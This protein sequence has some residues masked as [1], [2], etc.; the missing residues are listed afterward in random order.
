MKTAWV[1][2]SGGLLG[3]ALLRALA[4]SGADIFHPDRPIT[5]SATE[6]LDESI[7]MAVRRFGQRVAPANGWEIY[8]AAGVG[9]MGSD[10]GQ[11]QI[12]TRTLRILLQELARNDSLLAA[13]GAIAFAGS[14]GALYAG[15][16]DAVVSESSTLAP[17]TPYAFAK[18][19][20]EALLHEFC[21]AQPGH[22]LLIARISTLFGPQRAGRPG[23]GLFAHLAR[24]VFSHEPVKIFV[25]LDTMRDYVY[26][27]DAATAIVDILG[28]LSSR[29][30]VRM[31]IVA[32]ERVTTIADILALFGRVGRRQPRVVT[33]ATAL[34]SKY[35]S[36]LLFKSAVLPQVAQCYTTPLH[37]C[38]FRI[39]ESERQSLASARQAAPSPSTL[40]SRALEPEGVHHGQG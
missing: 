11:L 35:S 22:R 24:S 25:P 37:V 18:L 38:V 19:E 26:S 21:E 30:P 33:G 32:S 31:K 10:S 9:T 40:P 4:L 2:G 34:T 12:E 29:D 3:S 23:K 39:L 14:A 27:D 8:W 36:R 5:W 28:S 16:G 7:A 13:S 15:S 17:T 1:I 20:Q 6:T